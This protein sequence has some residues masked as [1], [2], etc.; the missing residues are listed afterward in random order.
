MS[1]A[2]TCRTC[3]GVPREGARFCDACGAPVTSTHPPAEYKQ[4]TVLFADVVRSMDIAAAEGPERLR[5]L[6][7]DLL[8][9]STTVVKRYGGTLSQFTGD[10][11]MAVFGAPITLEDHAFRACMAALDIQTEAGSTLA[12]RIGLN[13]GQVIAGEIGS[14]TPSYTTIG[15]Q[16]G[17]AQRMESV[18]PTGGVMLSESTAHLVENAVTLGESELVHIKGVSDAVR[19]RR[20]LTIGEPRFSR[21]NDAA[22]VGRTWELNTVTGILD[23]V[24]NGTGYIVGVMGPSGIGKSRLIR[25]TAAIATARG[26]EVFSVHCESH[27]GDVSFY[28]VARLLRAALGIDGMDATKSRMRVRERFADAAGEDLVLLDDLLG[29][30][31]TELDLPEIAADARRRRLTALVNAATLASN[32]PG[33]YVIEDVHWIDEASESLLA[34]FLAV[35]P[36]T[37]LLT[38]ISYRPEYQGALS[39]VSSAQTIALQPLSEAHA[40]ALTTEL[41]G[42]DP[43]VTAVGAT[44]TE[45]AS[46]NPFFVE[47]MVRDL[48]ERNVLEGQPG[49][50][51]LRREIS[52]DDVP[53]TLQAT[54][55][56]RI[57]RLDAAAKRTLNAAAVIGSRFDTTLLSTLVDDA[58]IAPLIAAELIEQVRFGSRAEYAFRQ[59]LIRAVAHESQLRSDRA[60]LHRRVAQTIE[61]HGAADENASLIAEHL[62]AAGDLR[63]AFK[64]HMRAGDW[65]NI[66]D[67]NAALTSWRRARD[68][69][70]R[71]PTDDPD[72]PT[73]RI[74]PRTLLCATAMRTRG[75][76]ADTGYD[77]LRELCVAAGDQVSLAIA[78]AGH[79]LELY[80]R[81]RHAEASKAATE[82]D[83]LLEAIGN[84][85]L[86]LALAAAAMS[87][88]QQTLEMTEVLRLAERSVDLAEGDATR[89][90]MMTGSPL[91]LAV[92]F[93]GMARCFLGIAGW[94]DD[95]VQAAELAQQAEPITRA[96]AMYFTY[97]V[98]IMNGVL[99]PDAALLHEAEEVRRVAVQSGEDV[100][101]AQ[102]DQYAGIIL[103]RLGGSSRAKG[104]QLTEKVRGMTLQGRYNMAVLPLIELQFAEEKTKV[105]DYV[106]AIAQ[107]RPAVNEFFGM[108]DMVS[109]GY[110]TNVFVE[111]LVRSGSA[112]DVLEAKAAVDRLASLPVEPTIVVHKLWLLRAQTL[113]A[114]A[115]GDQ[116]KYRELRDSYRKM[117]TDLG[118]EGH[119]TWAEA[120][121]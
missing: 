29:I 83:Q 27:T 104:V 60:R 2:L 23:E 84:P 19:A 14:N 36:R 47:E 100:A 54:I 107:S 64:W 75:S 57:D 92:A 48:A 73:M 31:D 40:S 70:D 51:V 72:R 99:T 71:L 45:R 91:T 101:V 18:A 62:E 79:V 82:L 30:R 61:A 55:G 93:R 21:R 96:A 10:G 41:L 5:E 109:G 119:M 115:E 35:I 94:R 7:A 8:D 38:L 65:S 81:A 4:V 32:E 9:R 50:Y 20:L 52:D 111:A 67:N 34:D 58:D 116:A 80:F 97:I 118:F 49:A 87:V 37:R 42:T 112:T 3:G 69:A 24:I 95:F 77:E 103:L 6:M 85:T 66:R 113:L 11:I 25:E 15:E 1:A 89:G 102:G 78:T 114:R 26:V 120:M 121:L 110:A 13:S 59:P 46:G 108:G 28:A 106:G 90:K 63:A 16:V 22:L 98:A 33:V 86:T 39:R 56:A 105:G 88:K 53:A 76:G 17:M 68:V 74:A 44:I 43:S 117:A 12:L